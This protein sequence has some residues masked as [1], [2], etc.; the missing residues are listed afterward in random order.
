MD[1]ISI[2]IYDPETKEQSKECGHSDSVSKEVQ[3]T[4]VNKQGFGI[5]LLGQ[6]EF[7]L[8][9]TCKWMQLSRQSTTLHFLTN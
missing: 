3:D 7:C 9:A 4:E 2:H 1:E 5:C 8:Q 6:E